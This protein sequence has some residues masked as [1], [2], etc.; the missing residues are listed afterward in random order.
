MLAA[1]QNHTDAVKAGM[2]NAIR[3]L[4]ANPRDL[5]AM[6]VYT[7]SL[8]FTKNYDQAEKVLRHAAESAPNSADLHR[9]LGILNLVKKN[10]PDARK[11]FRMAWNLQP[12]SR[13]L[14][15]SVDLGYVLANQAASGIQFLQQ[16]I[17]ARPNDAALR[18]ELARMYLWIGQRDNAI[19]TLQTAMKMEP[20]NPESDILLADVYASMNKPDQAYQVLSAATRKSGIDAD[21]LMLSGMVYE[22]IQR[23]DE[24]RKSYERSLM[25]DDNSAVVK[26]NLASVLADH[27]GDLNVALTLAQQA[28]EKMV[29]SPEINSTL[30]WIYYKRQLYPMALKYLDD[31]ANKDPKNATFVYQLACPHRGMPL[32]CGR[33]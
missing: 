16:A 12:T 21:L 30:G 2:G 14:L 18:F 23:W 13:Q 24:A 7:E 11:E 17:A 9:Q 5:A 33:L 3:L 19:A 26:N 25:L 32:S 8:I 22:H 1:L 10:I 20:T 15:E 29:D 27:G 4:Q 6:L 28:K 31:C